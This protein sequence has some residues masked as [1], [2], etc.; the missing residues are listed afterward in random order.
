MASKTTATTTATRTTEPTTITAIAHRGRVLPFLLLLPLFEITALVVEP[1]SVV[2]EAVASPEVVDA[3]AVV[4][5]ATAEEAV[6][7][8]A[9]V[10]TLVVLDAAEV[11][12]VTEAVEA[13]IDELRT[14]LLVTAEVAVTERA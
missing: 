12:E 6:V 3:S 1:L 5:D 4:V 8:A 14:V 2:S 9:T 11:A 13:D 7:D 10:P